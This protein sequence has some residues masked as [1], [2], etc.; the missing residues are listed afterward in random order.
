VIILKH[1]P[2]G[3]PTFF[4]FTGTSHSNRWMVFKWARESQRGERFAWIGAPPINGD[5][6]PTSAF[7]IMQDLLGFVGDFPGVCLASQR[8]VWLSNSPD[9]NLMIG[10]PEDRFPL[11]DLD[12]GS[13]QFLGTHTWARASASVIAIR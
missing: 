8:E 10:I 11:L 5:W 2:E 3:A 13:T 12:K 6:T 4:T 7:Q 1:E 9:P